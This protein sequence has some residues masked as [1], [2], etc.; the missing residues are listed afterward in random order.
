MKLLHSLL[1]ISI[2][3][4]MFS[5]GSKTDAPW[6]T[7]IALVM[8]AASN[9]FFARMEEGAREA[10]DSMGV[11][12]LVGTITRETDIEQQVSIVENMI[13]QSVQAILIAPADS[14]AIVNVLKKAADN[15]IRTINIDNRID[16]ATAAAAGLKID[17]Y[18]GVDNRE[19]GRMAGEYLVKLMGGQGKAAML[20]GIRGVD[21]A[22]AR[23]AGFLQAIEGTGIELVASQSANWAQDEGL[24]VFAN[25]LQAFPDITGLF[26]ANDMMALG[27]IQAIDQAGKTGQIFVTSYDNLEAARQAILQGNLHATI[28]QHPE[29]MGFEGVVAAVDLIQGSSVPAEKLIKLDLIT[30]EVL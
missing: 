25:M 1:L 4:L 19:G 20:E 8:K 28:E 10:A 12:L 27:A 30:K 9:P 16:S 29:R 17:C 23:K 21:N 2:S 6:K 15:G 7:K 22:E 13:V 26:C 5:C 3:L 11:N 18:I 14:K 24:D